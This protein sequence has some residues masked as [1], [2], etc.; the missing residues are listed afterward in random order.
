M[1]RFLSGGALF[2]LIVVLVAGASQAAG[3]LEVYRKAEQ[4]DPTFQVVQYRKLAVEEGKKQAI[5]QL[6]PNLAGSANYTY[7]S[8]EIKETDTEVY[9][10]GKSDYGTTSYGLTLTQPIFNWELFM[11]FSQSEA[12][13]TRTATEYAVAQQELIL[14]VTDIYL[15][16]LSAWDQFNYAKAEQLSVK[17]HFDLA[18][19]RHEEG[20][21]PITD[22]HDAKARLATNQAITIATQNRLDDALQAI[23]EMTGEPLSQLN[24]LNPEI[25]LVSP[26]PDDLQS[27][28][29][30]ALDQN[31]SIEM[32]KQAVEVAGYEIRKQRAGHYPSLNAVGRYS[33]EDS[34]DSLYGGG[35]EFDTF[36]AMLNLTFPLYQGG[37]VSSRIREAEHQQGVVRQELIRQ[38]RAVTRQVRSA[39]LGVNSAL[40][41]I[42]ALS[43]SVVANQLALEAKQEGYLSGL[44]A[45][46]DVLDA[47]R[48][49]SLVS[50]EYA[51]A[52]YRYILNGLKLKAAAGTLNPQDLVNLDKWFTAEK[53]GTPLGSQAGE[54]W[55]DTRKI[56]PPSIGIGGAGD[57]IKKDE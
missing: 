4:S 37:V 41:Q 10:L 3:L 15:L 17:K 11:G 32:Q 49:L 20:L 56:V 38:S 9:E 5:A 44:Y 16:A 57:I 31:L 14:R 13:N 30:G 48:D 28:L 46:L 19:Q 26:E 35:S 43:Q 54:M 51:R 12:E 18:R 24:S 39:F 50:I 53:T 33:N 22:F 47:E 7:T 21:T 25:S 42:S 27:W 40:S 6:L 55:I 23:E 8:Q 34:D 45:S 1:G 2:F 29:E 52:R 36:D